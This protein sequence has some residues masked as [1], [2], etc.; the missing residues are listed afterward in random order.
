[1]N[2][3]ALNVGSSSV[4]YALL[5]LPEETLLREGS[6][7][8]EGGD[9][10]SRAVEA[11]IE[12]CR[13]LGI[14]AVGHRVVHGGARFVQPTSID[15][16]TLAA[17]RELG[18][19][20]PVHSALEI[21]AMEQC[22]KVL[23]GVPSVAIFDTAFHSTLPDVASTYAI[24]SALSERLGLRRYG[25]HGTSYRYVSGLLRAKISAARLV[26]FHLG[27]GASVCA[28][29]DGRSVETSMGFTPLEGLVMGSRCGDLDP[30]LLLYLLR[31]GEATVAE[32][33]ET[34]NHESGMKGIAGESGDVR[35]LQ[36]RAAGG[37]SRAKLAL[38]VF[39]Y[40]ATKYLGAY[41]AAMGGLDAVAFTGGIGENSPAMRARICQGLEFLGIALD[42]K[43]N[44]GA[45]PPAP[46]LLSPENSAV[47]V[48]MV[49]TDEQRQIARETYALLQ[50]NV[51][52]SHE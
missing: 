48:W 50:N 33:E 21:A 20:N 13:A 32:L 31:T 46:A 3:L 5:R 10:A 16:E 35:V 1:M 44:Q 6:V 41:A 39:A 4:K 42:E 43:R 40:R 9:D 2:V 17:L 12:S 7:E 29:R 49:P 38:S 22:L 14:D 26:V 45:K 18:E 34:L 47:S 19:L 23:P 11:A 27:S 30:G 37:D 28:I 24:P 36:A 25:F 51:L 15:R 8:H 52:E